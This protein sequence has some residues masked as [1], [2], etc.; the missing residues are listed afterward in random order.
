M[1]VL[2]IA[3]LALAFLPILPAVFAGIALWGAHLGL[4][5]GL[6]SALVADA[7]PADRRGTAFGVFNLVTGIV[8]LVASVL[9]GLLWESAGPSVTFA[10]GAVFAAMAALMVLLGTWRRDTAGHM[11]R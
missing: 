11:R 1:G 7:A 6:L 3:D 10:A 4:T 9:A 8:L 2:I 5:Q